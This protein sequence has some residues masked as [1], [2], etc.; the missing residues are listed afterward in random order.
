M[1]YYIR[2]TGQG[3]GRSRSCNIISYYAGSDVERLGKKK[4]QLLM[5][6]VGINGQTHSDTLRNTTTYKYSILNVTKKQC[7]LIVLYSPTR[8]LNYGEHSVEM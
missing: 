8:K 2:Q 6:P 3:S 4:K 7:L 1:K 5:I